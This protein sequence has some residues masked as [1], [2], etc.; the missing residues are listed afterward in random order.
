[1]HARNRRPISL[2][3]LIAPTRST[4]ESR[5]TSSMLTTMRNSRQ[6]ASPGQKPTPRL[7][8][9]RRTPCTCHRIYSRHGLYGGLVRPDVTINGL[10]QAPSSSSSDADPVFVVSIQGSNHDR[11]RSFGII[12]WSGKRCASLTAKIPRARRST[13][14]STPRLIDQR[15]RRSH[16]QSVQDRYRFLPKHLRSCRPG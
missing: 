5:T 14:A 4:R 15:K 1:M 6:E 16:N 12:R 7:R 13:L 11:A 10:I 8:P 9:Q 2:S 3:R